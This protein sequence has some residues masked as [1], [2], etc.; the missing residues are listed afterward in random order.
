MEGINEYGEWRADYGIKWNEETEEERW[1]GQLG[2]IGA[3]KSA[4]YSGNSGVLGEPH[5]KKFFKSGFVHLLWEQ[6]K[7]FLGLLKQ[8]LSCL[9]IFLEWSSIPIACLMIWWMCLDFPKRILIYLKSMMC[10]VNGWHVRLIKVHMP[11]VLLNPGVNWVAWLTLWPW[12]PI[13]QNVSLTSTRLCGGT[14]Q[15][16]A[17]LIVMVSRP[18]IKRKMNSNIQTFQLNYSLIFMKVS[19]IGK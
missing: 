16:I 7:C 14:T 2:Q 6:M 5:Y 18:Q 13:L 9:F 10:P 1:E 15:K 17:F 19:T 12:R 3:L 4:V 11:A 8:K